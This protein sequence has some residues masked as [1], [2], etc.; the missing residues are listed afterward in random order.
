MDHHVLVMHPGDKDLITAQIA[1]RNG[2]TILFIKIQHGADRFAD[3]LAKTGV[4]VGALHGGK[5]QA[6]CTRPLNLFKEQENAALVAPDV[7]AR[8][9]H[10][11]G[12]SVVVHVDAP[13][14]HKDY[15]HCSGRTAHAGEAGGVVV[16]A[17]IKQ[18]SSVKGLTALAGVTPKFV[19]AKSNDA[20]VMTITGAQEPSG[21]HYVAPIT[22]LRGPARSGGKRP[23][24]NSSQRR[25]RP[26]C[27]LG[28]NS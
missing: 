5:S 2:K 18:Q 19:R 11:D 26:Q 16:F 9:I 24:P 25:R 3:N 21:I 15:L 10:V 22:E 6:V 20:E 7:A 28:Y 23:R 4:P 14:D 17:T 27:R 12:I 1:A 13:T 8:G